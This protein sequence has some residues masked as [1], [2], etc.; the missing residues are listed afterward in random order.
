MRH[1][2]LFGGAQLPLVMISVAFDNCLPHM[3]VISGFLLCSSHLCIRTY[4]SSP[5]VVLTLTFLCQACSEGVNGMKI[6]TVQHE[7]NVD[8]IETIPSLYQ[9]VMLE[10]MLRKILSSHNMNIMEKHSWNRFVVKGE[11]TFS[12]CKKNH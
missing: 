6:Q 4:L 2:E 1:I 11:S 12:L 5:T 10:W 7:D 3:L 8:T 9:Q